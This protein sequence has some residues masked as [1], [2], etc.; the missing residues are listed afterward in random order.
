VFEF[1]GLCGGVEHAAVNLKESMKRVL[2]ML[3]SRITLK[4]YLQP[5]G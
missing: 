2:E 3:S 4:V 5:H 1:S